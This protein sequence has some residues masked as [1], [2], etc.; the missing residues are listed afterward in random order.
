SGVDVVATCRDPSPGLV[1]SRRGAVAAG[2]ELNR[3]AIMSRTRNGTA[4]VAHVLEIA[5]L[6]VVLGSGWSCAP[7]DAAPA[8]E[9]ADADAIPGPQGTPVKTSG[10]TRT[11]TGQTRTEKD[12]LG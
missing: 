5:T 4:H 1:M 12:L 8:T 7:R 9:V 2:T 6:V 11:D 10:Q 3:K